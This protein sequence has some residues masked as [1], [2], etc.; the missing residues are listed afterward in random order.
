MGIYNHPGWF[1]APRRT[2]CFLLAYVDA[3]KKRYEQEGVFSSRQD[4]NKS[5]PLTSTVINLSKNTA[6]CPTILAN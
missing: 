6:Q 1:M 3:T 2:S 4:Q 5:N